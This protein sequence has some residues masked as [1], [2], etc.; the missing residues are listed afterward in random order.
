MPRIHLRHETGIEEFLDHLVAV[1]VN[2]RG[3]T[4]SEPEIRGELREVLRRDMMQA[5]ICGIF[6]NCSDVGF[7]DPFAVQAK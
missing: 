3:V 1:V 4:A 6:A 7:T 2:T 5:D